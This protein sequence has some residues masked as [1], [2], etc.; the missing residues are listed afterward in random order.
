MND[1]LTIFEEQ[2]EMKKE[3]IKFNG[4]QIVTVEIDGVVYVAM[5]N[6]VMSLGLDWK[7]QSVK[8][9]S[10]QRCGVI[11]PSLNTGYGFKQTICM[12]LKKLNGWLF[13]IN[14]Q[15]VREDLKD[16]RV[17]FKTIPSSTNGKKT[18]LNEEEVTTVKLKLQQNQHL[19]TSV[20]LPKT[21]FL[22]NIDFITGKYLPGSDIYNKR[23]AIE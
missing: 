3:I 8:I 13:S 17:A 9:Q 21:D 16:G 7:S 2:S 19:D 4:S 18:L 1:Q 15:K 23:E 6:I 14:P 22:Q 12:P 11:T 20:Q 5:R 10:D